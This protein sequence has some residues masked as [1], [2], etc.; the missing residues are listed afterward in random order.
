MMPAMARKSQ[1]PPLA[2][3]IARARRHPE[4]EEGIACAGTSLESRTLKVRGKAFAFFRPGSVMLK[5]GESL[6]EARAMAAK[7]PRQ[8][9][10]GAGGWVDVKF[11]DGEPL[12]IAVMQ[13]W[14]D[15]SYALFAAAPASPA[16][17]EKKAA[18]KK[19]KKAKQQPARR[20]SP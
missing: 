15:E 7:A 12:P 19:A 4:V 2:A 20:R 9:R 17:K 10:A 8:F 18:K 3:L 11:G 13:R 1:S 6:A 14:L 5:L 16:R